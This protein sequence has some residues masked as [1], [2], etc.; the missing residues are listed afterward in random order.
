MPLVGWLSSFGVSP[1]ESKRGSIRGLDSESSGFFALGRLSA[2]TTGA[3]RKKTPH[4]R[5]DWT[6]GQSQRFAR[7]RAKL[8]SLQN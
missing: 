8:H 5:I 4:E 7:T 2:R 3:N 6:S 1:E